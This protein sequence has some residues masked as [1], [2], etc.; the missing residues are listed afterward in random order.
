M[1]KKLLTLFILS[2]LQN[3]VLADISTDG[4]VGPAQNLTAINGQFTIGQ[5]LGSLKGSNLF[6][7]FQ[8]FSINNG[9]SAT[10]T[11]SNSIQNVISRVTGGEQ[12]VI[13]GLLQSQ[14]GTADFFFINPAGVV[15]GANAQIDVP[16]AFHFSTAG[17]LKFADGSSFNALIPGASTLTMA[18]PEVFGF[19]K[20]QSG[21]LQ[22]IGGDLVFKPSTEVSFSANNLIISGIETSSTE[23]NSASISVLQTDSTIESGINLNLSAVASESSQ[24]LPIT[25]L[26]EMTSGGGLLIEG[27]VI[28]VSGNGSGRLIVSAG[29]L[30]ANNSFMLA[31]NT[32]NQS[33][34]E[35]DGI[36]I[37]THSLLLNNTQV[38]N[39][40]LGQGSA[41]IISINVNENMQLL[42]GSSISSSTFSI[43]NT[44]SVIIQAGQLSID[45]QNNLIP[46]GILTNT[47][48]GSQG[49]AG[50][51]FVSV[52]EG[53]ELLNTGQISSNSFSSGNA[54]DVFVEAD[55]LTIDGQGNRQFATGIFSNSRFN[56]LGNAGAIFVTV[57]NT[58][59][60]FQGGTISSSTFGAGEAGDVSLVTN[61]LLIDGQNFNLFSTGV[62]SNAERGSSGN[63]GS[64]LTT[65]NNSI[66]LFKGGTIGS[67]TFGHGNAGNV[68][69]DAGSL[70]I[71]GQ[72]FN[73]F[74]TGILS[75]AEFGSN[76]NAG[77]IIV[78]V[79]ETIAL[80]NIGQISSNSFTNKDAGTI[81]VE[82]NQLFIDGQSNK[83]GILSE[84]FNPESF[85]N[86]GSIIVT[87]NDVLQIINGGGISSSAD[88]KGN[89]GSL[90][91]EAG[92][93]QIDGQGLGTGIFSET[94]NLEGIGNAGVVSVTVD[95]TL[96]ILNVGRVSSNSNS[97][98]EGGAVRINAGELL[99]DGQQD[100]NSQ[101]GI[102][103]L[104]TNFSSP[105]KAGNLDVFVDGKIQIFQGGSINSSVSGLGKGG[106]INIEAGQLFINGSLENNIITGI[107][108][109][110]LNFDTTNEGGTVS[111]KVLDNIQINDS[112]L[113]SSSTLGFGNAGDV[114]IEADQLTIQNITD[115]PAG[116]FSDALNVNTTGNAGRV[117]INITDKLT[118]F[119]GG[120]IN[121]SSITQGNAGI[122]QV[123]AGEILIDGQGKDIPTGIFS[124][125]PNPISVGNAGDVSV[126]AKGSLQLLSGGNISTAVA[127]LGNAGTVIVSADQLIIDGQGNPTIP[128]G[129]TSIT[130]NPLS[131]GF[132]GTV[133]IK[134]NQSLKVLNG[135][136]ISSSTFSQGA[137]GVVIVEAKNL[138]IE[139]MGPAGNV[140]N[141]PVVSNISSD[142]SGAGSAGNILVDIEDT[143]KISNGGRISTSTINQGNAGN[144]TV[145]AGTLLVDGQENGA[146]PT[147]VFSAS[148]VN[149]TGQVGNIFI[150]ATDQIILQQGVINISSAN[151]NLQ[152]NSEDINTIQAQIQIN[153]SQIQLENN[154]AITATAKGGVDAA[155]INID[156]TDNLN[157]LNSIITT[158]ADNGDGGAIKIIADNFFRLKNSQLTTSVSG[159]LNGNGGNISLNTPVLVLDTGF[160]QAN[161]V[162]ELA[163]G[164]DILLDIEQLIPS[165]SSL[166]RGGSVPI[167]FN[168]NRANFNV[169]Q[170][171]SPNGVSGTINISSPELNVVGALASVD[172]PDL[173]IENI[174]RDPCSSIQKNSLKSLGQGGVPAFQ[175]GENYL[176]IDRFNTPEKIETNIDLSQ[177]KFSTGNLK[178][179]G[180]AIECAKPE[181]DVLG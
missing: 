167:R 83:T 27:S 96:Q 61:Q 17:E 2:L 39:N 143:L 132:A 134:V 105:S 125:I 114:N 87:V 60:L 9:E 25:G 82:S 124:V 15:F 159:L 16:A 67:S 32:G 34:N 92:Q 71:D 79:D 169:I 107:V 158:S 47:L 78:T 157:V 20:G 75:N 89:A 149:S 72:G 90:I 52:R 56:S 117:S 156:S 161:T 44:G 81:F 110:A 122:I 84:T 118:I 94:S 43:S 95:G 152:S 45:G 146:N 48:E 41:G 54:G 108:S 66:E 59:K 28:N 177:A 65:A 171:A 102:F 115:R 86:S 174:G 93:L 53:I 145:E 141:L 127:G 162:A 113:I 166:I 153:A 129:V 38:T 62:L 73:L 165:A 121:S 14:I 21:S 24:N 19:S 128:T 49:N 30:V 91:I 6:H 99:I 181:N 116:V 31:N 5:E 3:G 50:S 8:K 170:A 76:G 109:F 155:Q 36:N 163:S 63:A 164:G 13:N 168:S 133:A 123:N 130:T 29:D 101:T 147:G 112:G 138:T 172:V 100:I 173:D 139:G 7:S 135:G 18:A 40:T 11:G 22:I 142:T 154:S 151:I 4:S 104:V 46:T 55:G 1:K 51:V 106:N 150:S 136:L 180:I 80:S 111:I 33:M 69:V 10:F 103:S 74:A 160:I 176:P 23:T 64:V 35:N 98:G 140:N 97:L 126:T 148:Q 137:A 178:Q 179:T 12:S 120:L 37:N 70:T 26:A 88:S 85:S 175:N 119:S 68:F 144:V 57:K 131:S 77:T 42:N 58:S